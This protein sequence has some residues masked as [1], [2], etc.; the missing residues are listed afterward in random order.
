MKEYTFGMN[1]TILTDIPQY[2]KK[3]CTDSQIPVKHCEWNRINFKAHKVSL[4][5]KPC[6]KL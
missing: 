1:N 4:S 2:T 3:C 6:R 5:F